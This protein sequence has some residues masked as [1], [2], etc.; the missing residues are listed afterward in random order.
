MKPLWSAAKGALST[1][2]V[3]KDNPLSGV[4]INGKM[5]Y[6]WTVGMAMDELFDPMNSEGRFNRGL[7]YVHDC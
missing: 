6:R 7:I 1:I 2:P 4:A 3:A 5:V